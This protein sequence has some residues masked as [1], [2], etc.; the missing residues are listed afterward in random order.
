[1]SNVYIINYDIQSHNHGLD[2][3]FNNIYQK[4]I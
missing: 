1:M 3:N 2:D 4:T